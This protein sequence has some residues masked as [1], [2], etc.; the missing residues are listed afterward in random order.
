MFESST[1][2]ITTEIA[3]VGAQTQALAQRY[4]GVFVD[5]RS[6]LRAELAQ[7]VNLAEAAVTAM[8]IADTAAD[9][10]MAHLPN[11]PVRACRA[12]CDAC[13]HLS[14]MVPP[15]V[16]EAIAAHLADRLDPASLADL[17]L[18]LK[19]AATAARA[20]PD[21]SI[22]RLRCPFL[23]AGGLCTIY[24]VRPPTCRAFT[25]TSAMACR[26]MVF[27]P[28]G[29]VATIPQNPSPF[30]AYVEATRALEQ[31]A[32]QRGLPAHQLGLAEAVLTVLTASA[33]PSAQATVP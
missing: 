5:L 33:P 31:T 3:S 26:S 23:G 32:R 22:L 10:F 11:Q 7:S 1:H 27:D 20:T 18:A 25:S 4:E 29:G 24:E 6:T 8:R 2:R 14:V 30:R 28:A 12:G 13:C 15:G 21:P 9:A 17:E 19:R 16:A